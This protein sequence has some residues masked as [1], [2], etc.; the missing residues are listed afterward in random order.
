MCGFCVN[1]CD[2]RRHPAAHHGR[3]R[4]SLT[5]VARSGV[6]EL[7]RPEAAARGAPAAATGGAQGAPAPSSSGVRDAAGA[8]GGAAEAA[9]D[10]R[11]EM[12][13]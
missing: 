8:R 1:R 3:P 12:S 2:P 13:G 9:A 5:R 7:A 10:W 4:Q 11:W 6:T